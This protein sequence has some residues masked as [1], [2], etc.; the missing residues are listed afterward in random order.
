MYSGTAGR[1]LSTLQ[2]YDLKQEAEGKYRSNSPLRPGSNSHGFCLVIHND[3]FGAFDDKVSGESGSLYQLAQL[4]GVET[5]HKPFIPEPTKRKYEGLKD[6][7]EAH[8]LT[9]QQL[10]LAG[11]KETTHQ[12]RPALSFPTDTGIRYRFLDG[13]QPAYKSDLGY[14]SCFYGLNRAI[15]LVKDN[16]LVLC[17]GEISTIA[18]QAHG[19]PAFCF[20]SGEKKM[21]EDLLA[22]LKSRWTGKIILAYDCDDTGNKA[23]RENWRVLVGY[24]VRIADLGFEK[25]GDLADFCQLF[26]A[27]S[28]QK[29]LE[30]SYYPIVEKERTNDL[31]ALSDAVMELSKTLRQEENE[32]RRQDVELQLAK[33]RVE[34][35]RMAQGSAKPKILS[36]MDVV[37]YDLKLIQERMVNPNNVIGLRCNIHALDKGIGGFPAEMYAIYG[38]TS[39]GKSWMTVSLAREFLKQGGGLFA[40]TESDPRRWALRLIGSMASV[41]SDKLESGHLTPD[42]FERVKDAASDLRKRS[43][44]FVYGGSPTVRLLR[45]AFLAGV[46]K[47]NY[48]FIIVDSASKMNAPG[49][50]GVYDRTTSVANELQELWQEFQVPLILTTQVGRDVAERGAGKKMPQMEDA[51]GSGAIEQNSGVVLGLYNHA[52]YVELGQEEP[53]P[54][55]PPNSVQ[56]RILKNR[57]RGNARKTLVRMAF[58][59]GLGMFNFQNGETL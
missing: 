32:K 26:D 3:E 2:S 22:E 36:I 59:D 12:N 50:N 16:T 54:A 44:D 35:D 29:L 8:G 40:T 57:W 39:M 17:N 14:K 47:F 42:E 24:D 27:E 41:A 49:T 7:G 52:Y 45:S 58:I 20:T 31:I 25:G 51:Y 23:A 38:A 21:P 1:V 34:M 37:D 43:G 9:E 10:G 5:A 4:I 30:V 11:W 55:Y 56:V 15:K 48:Q 28:W 46:E 53:N 19:L 18:A 6:Y 33:L 13:E